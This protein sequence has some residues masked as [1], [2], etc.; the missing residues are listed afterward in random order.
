ML[1]KRLQDKVTT[2][3]FRGAWMWGWRLG[4]FTGS[5]TLFTTTIS[6]YRG[7]SSIFE[8]LGGGTITGM[9][10][11]LK[12]GPKAMIAGG[13]VGGALGSIAGAVSLGL[14]YLTGTSMEE[15]RY[16]QYKWK[17]EYQEKKLEKLR[18]LRE[19]DMNPLLQSHEQVNTNDLLEAIDVEATTQVKSDVE[20]ATYNP[21][22]KPNIPK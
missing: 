14:M 10:Y 2:G 18:K 9:L 4:L 8:Y 19:A 6:V 20:V 11:K 15:M 7:K 22:E 5:I 12:S 13:V 17:E 1:K 16:W 3:F 21:Q